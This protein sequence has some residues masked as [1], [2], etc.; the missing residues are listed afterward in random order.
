MHIFYKICLVILLTAVAAGEAWGDDQVN[1]CH[2]AD[3]IVSTLT[4]LK[5]EELIK[6]EERVLQLCPDGNS[7]RFV[8][9]WRSNRSDALQKLADEHMASGNDEEAAEAYRQILGIDGTNNDKRYTFGLIY[10]RQG[11][12]KEA[13]EQF[14]YVVKQDPKNGDARRRLADIYT[15]QGDFPR[16]I[17]E[18][19]R[20]LTEYGDNPLL[21]FKLARAYVRDK[22]IQDGVLEYLEAIKLTPNNVEAHRELAALYLKN[23]NWDEAGKH[24]KAVLQFDNTDT[25]ARN[26]LTAVYI[27]LRKHDDL[28][29]LM[30]EDVE[31]FPGDPNSHFKLGLMY[32]FRKNY[33]ASIDQYQKALALKGD[34]AKALNGMGRVYLETGKFKKARVYLEAAKK[35]DPKQLVTHE[36]LDNLRI[37]Q[38]RISAAKAR[39]YKALK[40]LRKKQLKKLRKNQHKKHSVKAK[41]GGKKKNIKKSH[42]V[43]KKKKVKKSTKV[44]KRK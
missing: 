24:Y 2:E 36:L 35:A 10:E 9:E 32:N 16:A 12:L 38:S 41:G 31:L 22:K 34:H 6:Q 13:E 5:G 43:K 15:L 42:S 4:V 40:K 14:R 37:E 19:K 17:D 8:T 11:K 25:A 21:H 44:K 20:L 26:S 39:K 28:F 18:Y 30:K 1:R 29:S 27:K 23:S 7:G 33:D 3:A